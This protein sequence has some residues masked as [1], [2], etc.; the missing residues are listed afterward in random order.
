MKFQNPK[1]VLTDIQADGRTSPK[2]LLFQSW[3]IKMPRKL[4]SFDPD[5]AAS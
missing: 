5:L 2:Q 1:I 3:G 4:N